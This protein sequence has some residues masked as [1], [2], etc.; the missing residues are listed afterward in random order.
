MEGPGWGLMRNPARG[1]CD[2][3][4]GAIAQLRRIRFSKGVYTSI[5]LFTHC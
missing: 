4:A 2:L 5:N 1:R 3:P